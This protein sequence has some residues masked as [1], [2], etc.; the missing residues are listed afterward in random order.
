MEISNALNRTDRSGENYRDSGV[1]DMFRRPMEHPLYFLFLVFL[2]YLFVDLFATYLLRGKIEDWFIPIYHYVT[3]FIM[4]AVYYKRLLPVF[5]LHKRRL[6]AVFL[7]IVLL[8]TLVCI[9]LYVFKLMQY[10]LI[11]SKVFLVHEFLR[12]FHFLGFTTAFYIMYGNLRL[13]QENFEIEIKHEQLKVM[14]RS[15]QLSSHFVL[16]SLSIY[17]SKIIRLS[18]SLA[19]EFSN[20]TSLLRYSFKEFGEPNFLS[21]EVKAVEKYLQ[22]QSMRFPQLSLNAVIEVPPVAEGLPMPRMC[23]LTLV[24]NVFFH[25][26][27]TDAGHPCMIKFQLVREESDGNWKLT[28]TIANKV[29]KSGI[30]PRTGFGSSSVFQVLGQAFGDGFHYRVEPGQAFYSLHLTIHYGQAVQNWSD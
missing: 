11:L 23:L 28:V 2:C 10:P 26:D 21:E 4:I 29:G 1:I 30:K 25:G 19:R 12:V 20:L 5:F 9:K 6:L 14:H 8:A 7:L 27:Y 24:E 18:P 15:M 17:Q 3:G 13:K 22:I 16:N